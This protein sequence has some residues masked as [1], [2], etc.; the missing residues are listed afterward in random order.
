[1]VMDAVEIENLQQNHPG[2]EAMWDLL[3]GNTVPDNIWRKKSY[4]LKYLLRSIVYF[5]ATCHFMN[6]VAAK[7]WYPTMLSVQRTFPGKIHRHYSR[8]GLTAMERAK[9]ITHHYQF[10]QQL[11]SSALVEAF[12]SGKIATLFQL[13][14]K[15]QQLF[16]V[17][18][19]SANNGEREGESTLWLRSGDTVLASL[20]F[21]IALE[22]GIA[23]MNIGG[24]QGPRRQVGPEVIKEA[25]KDCYGLFP[26]RILYEVASLLCARFGISHITGVSD[27]G[28][29]F[30]GLRYRFKKAK[31][32][33][34][35]YS[36]FW[37]TLGG[38]PL[39]RY[40]YTLP[41][42]IDRKSMNEIP[43]KK[44]SEY[45]KRY[46]LMDVLAEKFNQL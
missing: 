19:G 44:R 43:S 37:Q 14:G 28:H 23:V 8:L 1:M 15:N 33:H 32:F 20:T 7:P 36:E 27:E 16:T 10:L 30:R 26:K 3:A 24:L 46:E 25:T 6:N 34:A 40:R 29:I 41:L 45:R 11:S 42:T 2:L 12:M 9:A 31:C 38:T 17:A 39:D 18:A 4:R 13:A 35:S 21:C 22:N 5:R